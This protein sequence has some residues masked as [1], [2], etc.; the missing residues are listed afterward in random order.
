MYFYQIPKQ[1]NKTSSDKI[2]G[3][4]DCSGSMESN[5]VWLANHWNLFIPT[6]NSQIITFDT[7]AK[8]PA[9]N[10]LDQ[11]INKH[12][13][14]GTNITEGFNKLDQ[15]LSL[16]PNGSQVTI[17]F[18][19]DGEDNNAATLN[20][21]MDNLKGND[22]SKRINFI[23]IGVGPGFPT[24]IS[25]KLRQKYHNGDDT[26]PAIFL[27]EHVSEK[28]Y[29][30]KFEAIKPFLNVGQ[31]V[32]VSPPVC[33]FPWREYSGEPFESSWIMSDSPVIN[34]DGQVIDLKDNLLSFQGINEIFRSWNQM[35]N[36]ESMKDGEK[37][38]SRA[39]KTLSLMQSILEEL[40][41]VKGVDVFDN[42]NNTKFETFFQ[43][44]EFKVNRRNFERIIWYFEDVKKIAEGQTVGK[45]SQ[46][47]AAKRI[48][49]GTIVGRAAQKAFGLKNIGSEEFNQ[50]KNE[51]K[52]LLSKHTVSHKNTISNNNTLADENSIPEKQTTSDKNP[53][54]DKNEVNQFRE[55]LREKDL[56]DALNL[57]PNQLVLFENLP[58][59]GIPVRVVKADNNNL[60]L[61]NIDIRFVAEN[62]TKQLTD[63]T[64]QEGGSL[65]L[66][67][68]EG[69]TEAVN[70]VIPLFD[71]TDTDL[72][73]FLTSRLFKLHL[74]FDLTR[75]PDAIIEQPLLI[76]IAGL[77]K[78]NLQKSQPSVS[79]QNRIISTLNLLKPVLP[80]D[81]FF[82]KPYDSSLKSLIY[83]KDDNNN[84]NKVNYDKAF[85]NLLTRL[86]A[87]EIDTKTLKKVTKFYIADEINSVLTKESFKVKN[88]FNHKIKETK[89]VEN[90]VD[91]LK[92][93]RLVL[94]KCRSFGDLTR[95]LAFQI[96]SLELN[97]EIELEFAESKIDKI[98]SDNFK[99]E[100][101]NKLLKSFGEEALS[102]NDLEECVLLRTEILT[103]PDIIGLDKKDL[104]NER[105][106]LIPL[107]K[108]DI[109]HKMK[110][111]VQETKV[112]KGKHKGKKV[113][114]Q[115]VPDIGEENASATTEL[116]SHPLFVKTYS[117]LKTEMIELFK[118]NHNQVVPQSVEEMKEYCKSNG[119]NFN[120]IKMSESLLPTRTCCAKDCHFYLR[121]M[122]RLDSHMA[123]W[124]FNLPKGFHLMV[125]NNRLLETNNIY[126][127]FCNSH[128]SQ[129]NGVTVPFSP[130]QFGKSKDEVFDYINNLKAVYNKILS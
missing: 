107:F 84:Q 128:F 96:L 24:F 61:E 113:K 65:L 54:G 50:I 58:L 12:G 80:K 121:P 17:V 60:D 91:L 21:R 75:N 46:F 30:I 87:G 11:S 100:S 28:A 36:L 8:I 48:G 127:L 16:L 119:I 110:K 72:L 59:Y 38:E 34:V 27:I 47:E 56:S 71:D 112:V 78:H 2:I 53:L 31:K 123:I 94:H 86:K 117:I 95:K 14:G 7:K 42:G 85:L 20:T 66:P 122:K 29:T 13:G 105:T 18:I 43:K 124:G 22:G 57:L 9:E 90:D 19:S 130:E 82:T 15:E 93:M 125:K 26:L 4:I 45:L 129:K 37:V 109:D 35:I 114:T 63:I 118:K 49:L 92:K 73:P 88:V 111:S 70:T 40:K 62:T 120:N 64:E 5:W 23:C 108:Q 44:V 83:E 6:E 1:K 98:L 115:V 126:D 76:L 41:Q 74:S 39:K 52:D 69:K 97:S 10:R 106:K 89:E 116:K 51:F 77:F 79:L 32:L 101:F 3:V 33:V 68:D 81:D 67:V 55:L 103:N 99:L 102:E 104:T 25:M